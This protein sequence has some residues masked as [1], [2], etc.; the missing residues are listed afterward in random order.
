MAHHTGT[1]HNGIDTDHASRQMIAAF[2]YGFVITIFPVGS[3]SILPLI[4]FLTR[5]TRNQF[6]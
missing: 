2:H 6:H 5:S 4:A 1:N 3:L